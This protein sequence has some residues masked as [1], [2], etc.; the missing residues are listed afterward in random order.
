MKIPDEVYT[1]LSTT[2]RVRASVL[3]SARDDE[4]EL[5]ILKATCPKK[6]LLVTDPEYS[7]G[8][9]NLFSLLLMVENVLS[10]SALDFLISRLRM[11]IKR[12]DN[13]EYALK[14]TASIVVALGQLIV[15]MGLDLEAMTK[16]A[17]PRH[18]YVHA[19][20]VMSEGEED[21]ELVN[22]HLQ[23]MRDHLAA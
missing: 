2:E 15:E 20:I 6:S 22:L 5:Q 17:P 18:P 9:A 16:N 21:H 12:Y 1:N 11:G 19:T 7:E 13:Q 23:F 8:M 10:T 14:S 4:A 3:A